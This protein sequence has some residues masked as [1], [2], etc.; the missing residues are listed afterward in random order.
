ML[1]N[2]VAL[3]FSASAANV[4]VS[5]AQANHVI[6]KAVEAMGGLD[7]IHAIHSLVLKG[8]H[9]EGNYHQEYASTQNSKAVMIRMRPN[10]RLV[11]CRPEIAACDGQWG[12]I[13]EG[14]DG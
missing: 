12:R 11:G 9:Y 13:V 3:A 4:P 14:Y 2:L 5:S 8:Y 7:H 1:T 6:A 10:L